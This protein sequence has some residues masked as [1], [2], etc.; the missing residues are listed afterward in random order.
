[1]GLPSVEAGRAWLV[2]LLNGPGGPR[3]ALKTT[4]DDRAETSVKA[5]YRYLWRLGHAEKSAAFACSVDQLIAGLMPV[6]GWRDH[7]DPAANRS[8]HSRSVRRWLDR[9]AAMGVIEW[10]GVRDN[11]NRWW[12]TEIW[13]LTPPE[14][15]PLW[16]EAACQRLRAFERRE[17]RR[18]R[19]SPRRRRD[20]GHVL[21]RSQA[22]GTKARRRGAL[23]R[24][25]QVSA[26]RRA[27]QTLACSPD[28]NV[29]SNPFGA[30]ASQEQHHQLDANSSSLLHDHTETRPTFVNR[31]G[32]R[33]RD[34]D[35]PATPRLPTEGS[36][37]PA[38]GKEPSEN[39]GRCVV[40]RCEASGVD[41][42]WEL[43][44]AALLERIAA[45]EAAIR[46][47]TEA[48]TKYHI[49]A[50]TRRRSY[51][52]LLSWSAGQPVPDRVLG[53]AF[54]HVTGQSARMWRDGRHREP[55]ARAMERYRRYVEQRPSGWPESPAAALALAMLD[56]A[57]NPRSVDELGYSRGPLSL[58]WA[59][60][61]LNIISKQMAAAAKRQDRA[62][63]L[64]RRRRRLARR[65][66]RASRVPIAFRRAPTLAR[67]STSAEHQRRVAIEQLLRGELAG[68]ADLIGFLVRARDLLDRGQV[69][70]P[71]R[72]PDQP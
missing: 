19:R 11:M 10:T 31:E 50:A 72:R 61:R 24:G 15:D 47:G 66:R 20:L 30:P 34:E 60:G 55:L 26:T 70:D 52:A 65:D 28:P 36:G 64:E 23:R 5:V 27:R 35:D 46:A 12:R 41:A 4:W 29:R 39:E 18:R 49:I 48:P 1:V 51:E 37:N 3:F 16:L 57:Q 22:P 32:A 13:L 58:S 56:C 67:E 17:R 21:A 40:D 14:P 69:P 25:L 9:L 68:G 45:R 44:S 8:A 6:M 7:G 43:S 38:N 53:E 33:A 62:R 59:I 54:E 42:Q 71:S 63:E 2:A